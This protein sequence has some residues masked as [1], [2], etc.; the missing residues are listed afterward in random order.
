MSIQTPARLRAEH[1]DRQAFI[2][3]RQSTLAQVREHTASTARQYHLVER[4]RTLGWPEEHI[5]VIDE[6]QAR[7][8]A[9]AAD[10]DGFARLS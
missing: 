8:G 5:T 2:Y 10:R 6:D 9:S 1:L 7:S 3:V 4:A